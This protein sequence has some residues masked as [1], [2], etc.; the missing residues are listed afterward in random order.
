[1]SASSD[2]ELEPYHGLEDHESFA[3]QSPTMDGRFHQIQLAHLQSRRVEYLFATAEQKKEIALSASNHLV[4]LAEK[5]GRQDKLAV[6]D[7]CLHN[8][9]S[10]PR[11]KT[12]FNRLRH[13]KQSV[14]STNIYNRV[15]SS[16]LQMAAQEEYN[17]VMWVSEAWEVYRAMVSGNEGVL[18]DHQTYA[19][20]L[21]AWRQFSD[22]PE[23]ADYKTILFHITTDSRKISLLDIVAHPCIP[24]QEDAA[25]ITKALARIALEKQD[26]DTVNILAKAASIASGDN[27]KIPEAVTA[28]KHTTDESGKVVSEVPFNIQNL[29]DHLANVAYARQVLPDDMV[30]RQRHLELSAYDMAAERLKFQH[31]KMNERG[32]DNRYQDKVLQE[33]MYSWHSKLSER[34]AKEIKII[35]QE[36]ANKIF[37][38]SATEL[39]PYLSL[40]APDRLSMITILEAM[41]LTGTGGISNGMKTTRAMVTIGKAVENEYKARMCK[42]NGISLP[43]V[44]RPDETVFTEFGYSNLHQRR[45]AAARQM[46]VGE[47]WTAP[48]SQLTRAQVGGVLLECLMDIAEITRSAKD[49][50]TGEVV[51]DTQPAFYHGYEFVRG[52]KLGVIKVNTAVSER[53]AK[54]P[55]GGVVHPRLLPMLIPPKPW[56][57]PSD[58]AYLFSKASL[59]RFKESV[60]QQKYLEAAVRSGNVELVMEGL[61]VLGRTPWKINK[62]VFDVVIQI[63]NSGERVGKIPPAQYDEA[64]PQAPVDESDLSA[65]SIWLQKHKLWQQNVANNHSDR[66]SVNYKIEIARVYADETIYFPHN[67]D[68]RGRAYPIP[69]HLNHMGDDLSRGLLQFATTKPLGERGFRWL[70]IHLANLCGFDKADFDERVEW[71]HERVDQIKES[72]HNPLGGSRWWMKADDPWQCLAVCFELTAALES[73]DPLNF[74]SSLPVHQDGTCN[75]LQHYAA[76][77]GDSQ[78]AAQVNLAPVD[79]PSDVYTFVGKKVE[80]LVDEDAKNGN[81]HAIALQGKIT[82]KVVKQTVMTTVYGVTFV[83]ARDQLHKQLSDRGDIPEELCWLSSAY[84]AKKVLACIGDTFVGAQ[85]IQTWLNLCARLISKSISPERFERRVVKQQEEMEK[86]EKAKLKK[87]AKAAKGLAASSSSSKAKAVVVSAEDLEEGEEDEGRS[88]KPFAVP[89]AKMKKEQMTS[90]IWTTALGLPIVQPYRK[91]AR[92]QV[93]TN[94]QSVYISDP[95]VPSEV[96]TMK[97][98]SAF[99]PNFVHSLDATHMILTAIECSSRNLTFAAV[100]DSY[101][102]HACD[103]DQMSAIIRD[104]FINLH[105]SDML[106]RLSAEFKERYK[107][108]RIPVMHLE[109]QTSLNKKLVAA[110][111]RV[112]MSPEQAATY[113]ALGTLIEVTE[114][115]SEQAKVV[116]SDLA[117]L[118]GVVVTSSPK[119]DS[120]LPSAADLA[121]DILASL[122]EGE[123]A[124]ASSTEVE[125][126]PEAQKGSALKEENLEYLMNKFVDVTELLP[127]LPEK[128]SFDVNDIRKSLYFFS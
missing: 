88:K 81:V 103:I 87:K 35:E 30:A 98:A 21:N 57:G 82:R 120:D 86:K 28:L 26:I 106:K 110:G 111:A 99:P 36:E 77:G 64:E 40:V 124:S 1:M 3:R 71:V 97:Q 22:I 65:R 25:D 67:L 94:L 46:T 17:R 8:L 9:Y 19:L 119:K 117:G 100:H 105:A 122:K 78:G 107:N 72:A 75:G 50:K 93:M 104:T 80:R 42:T 7:A 48:W 4:M 2:A 41:R 125:E 37:R 12:L 85:S 54:D 113:K 74:Q 90:V 61:N 34:L 126:T 45:L 38:N 43:S 62:Q 79:R 63:W 128:G 27:L 89:M 102:T 18:P 95:N 59:M 5:A 14:L 6:M 31:D 109:R 96:N 101:W 24:T 68:F 108:Y 127:P 15:M 66:C 11:A 76:M 32:L 116:E 60:E 83:G 69:P 47:S 123:D 10:V 84:L 53:I 29:R 33:Y 20:A 112:K 51:Y 115:T 58:G 16:Y 49:R 13:E 114:E 118:D 23:G 91:S 121:K 44:T 52:N 70:K 92:R 73:G 55:L 39:T 56:V